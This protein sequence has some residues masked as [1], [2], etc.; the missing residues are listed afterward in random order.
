M[1]QATMGSCFFTRVRLLPSGVRAPRKLCGLFEFEHG[2][3]LKDLGAISQALG[4]AI[5]IGAASAPKAARNSM[6]RS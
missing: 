1:Q 3:S 4:E 6:S 2:V 5:T